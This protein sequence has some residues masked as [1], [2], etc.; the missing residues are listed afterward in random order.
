MASSGIEE[1]RR[2]LYIRDKRSGLYF[3]ID[4]GAAVSVVPPSSLQ[5][6][7][8][9]DFNLYAANGSTIKTYGERAGTLD[10]GL[11]RTFKWNFVVADIPKP[12]IGADFMYTYELLVDLNGRQLIDK[13]TGRTSFG[14][15]LSQPVYV[16]STLPESLKYGD[17]LRDFP[18]IIR[19]NAMTREVK[20]QVQHVIETTGRPVNAKARRLHP[21]KY[22]A[23][24]EEFQRMM[25][26]GICRP[27]RSPWASPLH[28]V[29]KKDGTLRPCGDYR[30]LNS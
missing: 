18:G 12:I 17:I 27:S 10:L 15:V 30:Q 25:E 26:E 4:T 20:H 6:R 3:L 24:K 28:V 23:V 13:K 8:P 1:S 16:I 14:K 11:G 22:K 5:K 9:C 19:P 21:A 29:D 2:R 7:N